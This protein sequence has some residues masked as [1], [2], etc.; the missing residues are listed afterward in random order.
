MKYAILILLFPFAV[1]AQIRPHIEHEKPPEIK[2]NWKGA[3]A[4]ASMAFAAGLCG[5]GEPVQKFT[6][7]GFIAGAGLTIGFG[8]NPKRPGWHYLADALLSAG[9]FAL[10]VF[11]GETLIYK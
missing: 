3:I 1:S 6:R 10:G 11:A 2:Y 4:P 7:Q 8:S 9:G 5:S